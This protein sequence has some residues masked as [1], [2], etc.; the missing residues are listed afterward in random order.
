MVTKR[1]HLPRC[2][3][4]ATI[5][6]AFVLPFLAMIVVL[7]AMAITP[8]HYSEFWASMVS[9]AV[10]LITYR[11]FRHGRYPVAQPGVS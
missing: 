4:T 5:E 9:I 2:K 6:L 11:L 1:M 3:G 7:I 10:A 8:S